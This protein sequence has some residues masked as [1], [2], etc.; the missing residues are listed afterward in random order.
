VCVCVCERE[1]VCECVG[2]QQKNIIDTSL[3]DFLAV[4][5]NNKKIKKKNHIRYSKSI[6]KVKFDSFKIEQVAPNKSSLILQIIYINTLTTIY[7][8]Y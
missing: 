2:T 5:E 4:I 1:S 3:I 8:E 6:L 7:N